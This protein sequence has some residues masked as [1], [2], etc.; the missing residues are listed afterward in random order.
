MSTKT[1]I[2]FYGGCT[3]INKSKILEDTVKEIPD[4]NENNFKIIKISDL[5]LEEIK[6]NNTGKKSILWKEEHWKEHEH[7]VLGNLIKDIKGKLKLFIINNHFATI[8]PYGY[9]PGL[10]MDRLEELLKK[11]IDK[12]AIKSN[13][14]LNEKPVVGILHIDIN[15]DVIYE[16]YR[17]IFLNE[18]DNKKDNVVAVLPYISKTEIEKDL[19]ENRLWAEAYNM[20]ARSVLPN[21]W[22]KSKTIYQDKENTGLKKTTQDISTF[23]KEFIY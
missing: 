20:M 19:N 13:K 23:I 6:K 11:C 10:N 14:K 3:G 21:G 2:I 8:S 22:V 4:V 18:V 9:I 5:F 12:T 1:R 17:N 15:I 16:H 7:E